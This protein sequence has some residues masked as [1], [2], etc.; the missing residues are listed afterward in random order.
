MYEYALMDLLLAVIDN[1]CSQISRWKKPVNYKTLFKL[2]INY[3]HELKSFITLWHVFCFS[4][5]Q[6]NCLYLYN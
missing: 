1:R 2:V 5:T 6:V 4:Q 3:K